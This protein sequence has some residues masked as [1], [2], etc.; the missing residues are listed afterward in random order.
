MSEKP[1]V[2]RMALFQARNN[3]SIVNQRHELVAVDALAMKFV[4]LLDGTNSK[5]TLLVE[6]EKFVQAVFDRDQS[7]IATGAAIEDELNTFLDKF[8][9]IGLFVG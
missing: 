8:K 4:S 9:S 6:F 3:Y 2:S 7:T 1:K 5:K